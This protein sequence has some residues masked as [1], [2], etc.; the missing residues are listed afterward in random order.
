M[1]QIKGGP[2]ELNKLLERVYRQCMLTRK[3]ET[4]CSKIAWGAAKNAGWY[5]DK[6][7]KWKKR[8]KGKKQ[9]SAIMLYERGMEIEEGKYYAFKFD[10]ILGNTGQDT[11]SIS[12]S[13]AE[14]AKGEGYRATIVIGDRF[15]KGIFVSAKETESVHKQWNNTLHDLNHMG[16]GYRVMFSVVPSDISYVVGYQDDAKYDKST[17][18]T[19]VAVHIEENSPRYNE[20]KSY[21]AICEKINRTPNVSM[22][23][24]GKLEF[25]KAKDLP[26][27]SH[28]KKNGYRTEDDV[29]CM[30]KIIPFMVS[31]VMRG[32]CNDKDGCGIKHGD[33]CKDNSC[34]VGSTEQPD[35][36]DNP[37]ITKRK[38]YLNK[39][40]KSLRGK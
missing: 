8:K 32:A 3:N 28:Y 31:T 39:R 29:P 26:K 2:K 20:W 33:D 37:E 17:K 7:G 36:I 21:I 22:Y 13:F 14:K 9:Q 27:D 10:S 1:P 12:K 34:K 25:I 35:E 18:E 38:D 15:M 4:K 40:L 11:A 23:C 16:S 19:T 30:T 5:K 24:F 6:D